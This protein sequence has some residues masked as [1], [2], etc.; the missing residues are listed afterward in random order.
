MQ[1]WRNGQE[2]AHSIELN[3][4]KEISLFAVFDGHGGP[5]VAEWSSKS[6]PNSIRERILKQKI[7]CLSN[8]SEPLKELFIEHGKKK[9]LTKIS[10]FDKKTFL[11][12][13][14]IFDKK[15]LFLSKISIS[16]K[17]IYI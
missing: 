1:G 2:D 7:K 4:T 12:K 17:T 11:T 15:K 10:M 3:L 16:D 8:F 6:L 13:I 9:K 14:S 5:E